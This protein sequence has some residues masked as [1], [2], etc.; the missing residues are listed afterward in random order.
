MD[1]MRPNLNA[2]Y[3]LIE[4]WSSGVLTSEE[5]F[6]HLEKLM[7]PDCFVPISDLA[8]I[9]NVKIENQSE[10]ILAI[11]RR[12]EIRLAALTAHLD[13]P[14][15]DD[16]N[17]KVLLDDVRKL[18][19]AGNTITAVSVHRRRTGCGLAEAKQVCDEYLRDRGESLR[20]HLK[21]GQ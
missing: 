11:V 20:G 8:P 2:I 7:S 12:I 16:L 14:L 1:T 19:D 10:D 9:G 3:R 15:P 17:P 5:T 6:Q 4:T 21:A 13:T 18:L